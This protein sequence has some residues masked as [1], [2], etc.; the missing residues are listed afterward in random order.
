MNL[1]LAILPINLCR[2]FVGEQL[3]R[4]SKLR[5][6]LLTNH[7]TMCF[8]LCMP[9]EVCRCAISARVAASNCK[10]LDGNYFGL[11]ANGV[12]VKDSKRQ[13]L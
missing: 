4:V 13:E 12:H 7:N 8:F 6:I 9:R 1:L 2:L 3:F 11:V 5:N 10:M